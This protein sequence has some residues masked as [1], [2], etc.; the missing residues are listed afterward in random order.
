MAAI[1]ARKTRLAGSHRRRAAS[2]VRRMGDQDPRDPAPPRQPTNLGP[3][4]EPQ[5]QGANVT[6]DSSGRLR[7]VGVETGQGELRYDRDSTSGT[8]RDGVVGAANRAA[9][10]LLREALDNLARATTT[11]DIVR[12][13]TSVYAMA[14]NLVR[15]HDSWE[16]GL[17]QEFEA[18]LPYEVSS[19][20]LQ[21][22]THA[23]DAVHQA[24][25]AVHQ[26]A[27]SWV[28][29]NPNQRLSSSMFPALIQP[30]QGI[31]G[32]L[33]GAIDTAHNHIQTANHNG[34]SLLHQAISDLAGASDAETIVRYASTVFTMVN[35]LLHGDQWDGALADEVREWIS[36]SP[37]DAAL[38]ARDPLV[39]AAQAFAAS[40]DQM[41]SWYPYHALLGWTDAPVHDL[42]EAG[43]TARTA[44]ATP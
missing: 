28:A 21:E 29:A 12:Q 18:W 16:P 25:E 2:Y 5:Q 41:A 35:N 30:L 40:A 6:V 3:N 42:L 10:D 20:A 33:R 27:T 19:G 9:L 31:G 37:T 26:H 32:S 38:H 34:L 14:N 13:L 8:T 15:G 7:G 1:A 23:R 22:Y 44:V 4:E 36:L 24:G 11:E 39:T 43:H 17:Q